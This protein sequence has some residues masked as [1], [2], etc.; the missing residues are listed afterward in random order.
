MRR[1]DQ[2]CQQN[3]TRP[4]EFPNAMNTYLER[5]LL[6]YQQQRHDMAEQEL[7]RALIDE[8][9]EAMSHALFALCP[10]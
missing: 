6:L 10:G 1:L 2:Q 5:G 8:P 4:D 3:I 9:G 7:R